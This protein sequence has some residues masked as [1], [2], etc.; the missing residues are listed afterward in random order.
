LLY[1]ID[2]NSENFVPTP[3]DSNIIFEDGVTIEIVF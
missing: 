1:D 3:L 2:G